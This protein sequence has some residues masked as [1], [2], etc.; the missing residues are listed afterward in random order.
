MREG[1][2]R[3]CSLGRCPARGEG[4]ADAAAAHAQ[5]GASRCRAC[6]RASSAA[7][8]EAGQLPGAASARSAGVKGWWAV[9]AAEC[10]LRV[11]TAARMMLGGVC[12]AWRLLLH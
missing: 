3:R 5:L 9:A 7:V 2:W 10:E 8:R 12:Y 11:C 1:A 6:A 4:G